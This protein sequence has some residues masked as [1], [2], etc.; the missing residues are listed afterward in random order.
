MSVGNYKYKYWDKKTWTEVVQG[1]R[2]KSSTSNYGSAQAAISACGQRFDVRRGKA[3]C[4]GTYTVYGTKYVCNGRSY[5]TQGACRNATYASSSNKCRSKNFNC[6]KRSGIHLIAPYECPTNKKVTGKYDA[7][8]SKCYGYTCSR[9]GGQYSSS[10]C[11]GKCNV[12]CSSNS[13][14][15]RSSTNYNKVTYGYYY[16]S[17]SSIEKSQA[18][19]KD[20]FGSLNILNIKLMVEIEHIVFNQENKDPVVMNIV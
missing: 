18:S 4:D 6:V 5:S 17:V 2:I 11:G 13:S 10:T 3:K 9:S 16:R 7:C 15:C 14:Y 1:S 20:G 19:L 8:T 12:K